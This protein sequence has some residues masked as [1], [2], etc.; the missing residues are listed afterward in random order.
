MPSRSLPNLGLQAFFDLGEDGWNDEMDLNMLKL[1]TL[2]QGGVLGRVDSLPSSPTNGDVYLLNS[3]AVG[4]P[5]MIA[6]RDGGQWFYFEPSEGWLLYDRFANVY[7]TFNGT[8]WQELATGSNG[9]GGGSGSITGTSTLWSINFLPTQYQAPLT[10]FA[11]LD[12]RNNRPILEF[13]SQVSE[14]AFWTSRLPSEYLGDGLVV[15]VFF[16]ATSVTAGTVIWEVTFERLNTLGIDLDSDGFATPVS[17]GPVNVP[18]TS[19][20]IAKASVSL[21]N[22]TQLGG[23]IAGEL[24]R[25]RLRRDIS[26]NAPGDAEVI[27]VVV[28]SNTSNGSRGAGSQT[29]QVTDTSTNLLNSDRGKY[30]RWVTSGSKTLTIQPASIENIEPDSEFHVANRSATGNITLSAGVGVTL[31]LP[32]A[33]SNL[34]GPGMVVTIKNVG[35][36]VFDVMGQTVVI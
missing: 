15:E 36:N 27:A 29:L 32:F 34:I 7:V 33:G 10:N 12:L 35:E 22:D 3:T 1:S 30:Q 26:D 20:Q 13:D 17:L 28:R 4:N 2:V 18:S 14:S 5:N 23:L 31:N 24:F 6:V 9:G 19:G 8:V 11:T 16:S 25:L 21:N